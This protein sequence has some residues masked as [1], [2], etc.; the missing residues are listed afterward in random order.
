VQAI[1]FI[2]AAAKFQLSSSLWVLI[3][4]DNVPVNENPLLLPL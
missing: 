4:A 2:S 1:H 3:D